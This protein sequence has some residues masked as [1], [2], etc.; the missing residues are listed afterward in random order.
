MLS[1][2]A[3]TELISATSAVIASAL[4]AERAFM[5]T[6]SISSFVRGH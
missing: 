6:L 5:A 2:A 3:F 1:T 4:L